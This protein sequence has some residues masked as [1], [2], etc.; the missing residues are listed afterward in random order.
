MQWSRIRMYEELFRQ[1]REWQPEQLSA[2]EISPGGADSIWRRHAFGHYDGVDFPE[3]DIC[4]DVLEK[5][6]DVIIADQVF[7][8]LLWPYRAARNV[9]AMLKPGG[10]FIITTPFLIRY[11]PIPVDCSRWTELGMKHLL[12]EAGFEI[13]NI[14]SGSWGNKACVLANLLPPHWAPFG[15]GRSLENEPDFPV[16]VWAIAR[17]SPA[18][19]HPIAA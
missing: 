2:L 6:F 13:G 4:R 19:T 10:R 1:V 3:F 18:T 5:Q 12:A 8:H 15:W 16:V 7:E 17:N 9:R 14:E 11:H